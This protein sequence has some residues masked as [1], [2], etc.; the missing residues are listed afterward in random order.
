[1]NKRQRKKAIKNC[2]GRFLRSD[3]TCAAA[4]TTH[5]ADGWRYAYSQELAPPEEHGE[6][7]WMDAVNDDER[8]KT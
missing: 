5:V 2:W 6:Q 3:G 1:M 4:M 8:R 7:A